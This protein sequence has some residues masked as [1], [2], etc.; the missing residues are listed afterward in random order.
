MSA[1]ALVTIFVA[2]LGTSLLVGLLAVVLAVRHRARAAAGLGALAL[3]WLWLWSTPVASFLLRATLESQH[4]WVPAARLPTAEAIVVLGGAI[5]PPARPG[6]K[7]H[8]GDRS[9]RVLFAAQLY[10]A[11]RAPVLVLSGGSDPERSAYSEAQAM[12]VFLRYL[13]VPDAALLLEER[14]RNT[15]QNAQYSGELLRARHIGRVLLVTSALHMERA[16][17]E[18]RRAGVDAI[19]APTDFEA[20]RPPAWP[21]AALPDAEALEGSGRAFKELVG[22]WVV[23]RGR[24][25]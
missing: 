16:L 3:C 1:A 15:R 2:P 14:S 6:G 13:S 17:Q 5:A 22:Q 7:I 18:F 25:R 21:M 10:H 11:G 4:P 24:C 19:P 8:L 23:C 9:D 20:T 12:R